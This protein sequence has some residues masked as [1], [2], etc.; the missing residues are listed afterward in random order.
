[1]WFIFRAL[2]ENEPPFL[3][4]RTRLSTYFLLEPLFNITSLSIINFPTSSPQ[5]V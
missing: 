3:F 1:M 2:P 5:I 4:L